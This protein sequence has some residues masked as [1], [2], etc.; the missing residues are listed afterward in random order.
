MP[1]LNKG[2]NKAISFLILKL[3]LLLLLLY[4]VV[5]LLYK[6]GLSHEFYHIYARRTHKIMLVCLINSP[7]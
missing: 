3:I 1:I 5:E 2:L 6:I 4:I 7:Q